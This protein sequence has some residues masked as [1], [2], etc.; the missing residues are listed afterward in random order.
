[1]NNIGLG[2][3]TNIYIYF[4][5]LL[6]ETPRKGRKAGSLI[7]YF[8]YLTDKRQSFQEHKQL[9]T[10]NIAWLKFKTNDLCVKRSLTGSNILR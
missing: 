8:L 10:A 9:A 7:R 1:M 3:F 5:F 2:I 4:C 6:E